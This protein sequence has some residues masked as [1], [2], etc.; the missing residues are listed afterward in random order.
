[1]DA[2]RQF[3]IITVKNKAFGPTGHLDIRI[4]RDVPVK[5]V[6]RNLFDALSCDKKTL[7][8]YYAKSDRLKLII[9]PNSTF[10]DAEIY[11]GDIIEIL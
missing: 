2:L 11:D 1:M 3:A 4:S 9:F 6:I 5:E 10:R 8:G 7:N